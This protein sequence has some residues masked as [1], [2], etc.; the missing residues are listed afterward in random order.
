MSVS[1][2]FWQGV[3]AAVAAGLVFCLVSACKPAAPPPGPA[4]PVAAKTNAPAATTNLMAMN[5]SVFN[6]L[7]PPKG[8]DPFFP[9][10]HRREPVP[11]LASRPDRPPPPASELVLKG[12]VG[13]PAHRLAVINGAILEVGETDVVIVPG[14]HVKVK[15]LEIGEDYAVI[16]AEGEAQQ[17]RLELNKKGF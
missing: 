1:P 2:L 11:T 10:S 6:E 13:S 3:K 12:I 9:S 15:C 17:K 4:K 16:R 7:L 14:G 5:V 8:K